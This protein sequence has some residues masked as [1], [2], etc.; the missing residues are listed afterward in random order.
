MSDRIWYIFIVD[1]NF[2]VKY[3]LLDPIYNIFF[4]YCTFRINTLLENGV[5]PYYSQS[6][7]QITSGHPLYSLIS[8]HS[9]RCSEC[10]QGAS[11]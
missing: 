5:S 11:D 3:M 8:H 7:L 4:T 6:M 9:R 2:M 1:A 10:P